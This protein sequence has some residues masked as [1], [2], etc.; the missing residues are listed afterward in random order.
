LLNLKLAS[1]TDG[2]YVSTFA[3]DGG[4]GFMMGYGYAE[5]RIYLPASNG[6]LV[7]WPAWW[8]VGTNWPAD[9]EADIVE[10]LDGAATS[11]YHYSQNGSAQT[12]N[13]GTISGTWAA[14]GTSSASTGSPGRTTS[15]GTAA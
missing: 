1:S 4:G 10:G 6:Q 13:S 8:I 9:G 11:N 15:T 12:N 14:A 7:G 5:A 3:S 2:A